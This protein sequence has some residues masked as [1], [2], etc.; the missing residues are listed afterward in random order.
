MPL[1][2][3]TGHC[4]LFRSRRNRPRRFRGCARCQR[5]RERFGRDPGCGASDRPPPRPP[6][7]RRPRYL[8]GAGYPPRASCGA[9]LRTRTEID[10]LPGGR[11]DP[12]TP[13]SRLRPARRPRRV[14]LPV[15]RRGSEARRKP[16]GLRPGIPGSRPSVWEHPPAPAPRSGSRDRP[17]AGG[18]HPGSRRRAG[19]PDSSAVI[20]VRF[21][22]E[23]DQ[24]RRFPQIPAHARFEAP[25]VA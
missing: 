16:C 6:T 15:G 9:L 3:T 23:V 12:S 25:Q 14:R 22:L 18:G 11:K 2:G 7:R 17:P 21:D 19:E 8:R 20:P 24:V 13:R 4:R 5:C 1:T 10:P